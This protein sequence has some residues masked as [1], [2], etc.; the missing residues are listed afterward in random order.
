VTQAC[1]I[2]EESETT[3]ALE[4]LARQIGMSMYHFQR[5]F[6]QITGLTPRQ[7]AAGQRLQFQ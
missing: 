1:R 2:I 7:Y 5:V 4:D 3:L 6:K